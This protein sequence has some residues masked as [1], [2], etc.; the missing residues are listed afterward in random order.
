M[1]WF[2]WEP[3]IECVISRKEL[4]PI[5]KR[6]VP[7]AQLIWEDSEY[8]IPADPADVMRKIKSYKYRYIKQGRDCDDRVRIFQKILAVKIF[9]GLLSEAGMGNLLAMDTLLDYF[10]KRAQKIVR[11]KAITFLHDGELIFG[12]PGNGRIVTHPQVKIIRLIV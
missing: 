11:H 10:S 3:K 7:D 4:T 9:R 5:L 12:E 2:R 1:S 8:H 6:L